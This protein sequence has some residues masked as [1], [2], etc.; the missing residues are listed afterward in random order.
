MKK[1]AIVAM[2]TLLGVAVVAPSF[3]L[4]NKFGGYWDTRAYIQK[5]FNGEDNGDQDVSLVDTRTR[6]YYTAQINDNLKLV[7][8]FEMDTAW[9]SSKDKKGKGDHY[10]DI[11]A[12]GVDLEIKNSYADFTMGDVNFKIGVQGL[13]LARG[14][15]FD[16][17]FSGAVITYNG[18]GFKLPFIWIKGYEGGIGDDQSEDDVDYFALSPSFNMMDGNLTLNPYVLYAHCSYE[19]TSN[20]F[21]N[22]LGFVHNELN[23][24][25]VGIDLDYSADALS[26]WFT[27]IYEGGTVDDTDDEEYDISAF[28]VALGAGYDFGGFEIHGQTFYASGDDDMDDD[29]V[30]V[31]C[32]P[33]GQ[34]YYWAEIMGLGVFDDRGYSS[35]NSVNSNGDAISDIWAANLGASFKPMDKMTAT[36]DVWY[37]A[38]A[39]DINF[40]DEEEDQLGTEV[41]LKLSY[42]LMDNLTLDLVGAYL[43][44]GDATSLDGENDDDPYELGARLYIKF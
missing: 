14:F 10:G 2:A 25:F 7:N 23:A 6:L 20:E 39:E 11:A 27:G 26:L 43:F 38:R 36:F 5:N 35:D 30:E 1:L 37:A 8:K 32:A 15:I 24:W 4:E 19:D 12:D 29:D 33:T 44:A 42:Q 17:D 18:D 34:S 41:D 13:V 22:N 31:F 9:G 21:L 28:L 16:E 40:G 3:A